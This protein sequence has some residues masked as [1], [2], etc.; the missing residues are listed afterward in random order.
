MPLDLGFYTEDK[1]WSLI[2]E[3]KKLLRE[4]HHRCDMLVNCTNFELH[5]FYLLEE[6]QELNEWDKSGI[7]KVWVRLIKAFSIILCCSPRSKSFFSSHSPVSLQI[8]QYSLDLFS[9]SF[10]D[11]TC[12]KSSSSHWLCI[13][14]PFNSTGLS[15][16]ITQSN[17]AKISLK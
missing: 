7:T 9:L 6:S 15:N 10:Y 17:T 14:F 4:W 12:P 2:C 5:C 3:H 8:F 11:A 13:P 16:K 1:G